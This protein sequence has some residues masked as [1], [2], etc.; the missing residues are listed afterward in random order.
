[1]RGARGRSGSAGGVWVRCPS[2]TPLRAWPECGAELGRARRLAAGSLPAVPGNA[3]QSYSKCADPVIEKS[4]GAL[5]YTY[6]VCI[7]T[8]PIQ[9]DPE[10][11]AAHAKGAKVL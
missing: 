7:L 3:R 1:M 10:K 9:Y 11:A 2:V 6:I 4:T 5:L 8:M